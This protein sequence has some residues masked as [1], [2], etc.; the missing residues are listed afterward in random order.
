MD[1]QGTRSLT[2]YWLGGYWLEVGP[3]EINMK[4]AGSQETQSVARNPVH[5]LRE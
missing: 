5:G 3:H 2:K 4:W 1:V